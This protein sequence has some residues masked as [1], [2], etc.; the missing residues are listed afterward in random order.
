MIAGDG[1]RYGLPEVTL[2]LLPGNGGTQR[3][4]RLIGRNRALDLM[5]RG[6]TV[7]PAR[8]LE[9]GFVD[10]VVDGDVLRAAIDYV[11]ALAK[12]ALPSKDHDGS[13]VRTGR[14][15]YLQAAWLPPDPPPW[16]QIG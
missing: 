6:E 15:S 4:G 12:G 9:L 10:R 3:L 16:T 5:L 1:A 11:G 2:G 8:A 7:S 13:G 14:N